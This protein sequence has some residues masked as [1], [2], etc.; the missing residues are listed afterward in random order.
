MTKI[1]TPAKINKT[2]GEIEKLIDRSKRK[3]LELEVLLASE[4]IKSGAFDIFNCPGDLIKK[5]K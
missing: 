4:E 5:L 3:F 2:A 1:K